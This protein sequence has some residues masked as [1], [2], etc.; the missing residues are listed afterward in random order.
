MMENKEGRA[1]ITDIDGKALKQFL[2]FI[3][4]GRVENIHEVAT[5]LIYAASKYC[6]PD[7]KPLCVASLTEKL[8]AENVLDTIMLA[9]LHDEQDLKIF[10]IDFIKW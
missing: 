10:C 7:L 2:L 8:T 9:N 6:L 5:D 1:T 4:C 3:Y